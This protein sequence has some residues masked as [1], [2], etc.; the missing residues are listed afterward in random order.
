LFLGF[1]GWKFSRPFFLGLV[2]E[3]RVPGSQNSVPDFK[4]SMFLI[5]KK[6]SMV[7]VLR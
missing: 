1:R 6:S 7:K 3:L 5:K 4:F 2:Q